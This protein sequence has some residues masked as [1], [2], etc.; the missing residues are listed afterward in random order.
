MNGFLAEGVALVFG[1][2]HVPCFASYE[3]AVAVK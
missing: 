2:G 3:L 1:H